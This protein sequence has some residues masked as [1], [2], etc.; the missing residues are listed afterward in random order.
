MLEEKTA[1]M[2]WHYRRAEPDLGDLRAKQLMENLEGVIANTPLVIMQGSKVVEVKESGIGKGR[3]ALRWLDSDTIYD[4]ILATGDD[5]TD[6]EMFEVMPDGAWS[7]RI[8]V[9]RRS[10]AKYSLR[11]TSAF[12]SMLRS[13]VGD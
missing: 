1:S 6:E 12:R 5:V 10:A 3:A 2:A 13:L 11:G 9:D 8:G 7:I 4:F